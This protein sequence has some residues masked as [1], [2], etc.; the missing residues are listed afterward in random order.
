MIHKTAD[1][2][3]KKIGENTVIWQN[4]IVLENAEIGENCNINCHCF[5]ENDVKIGDNCTIKSGVYLWD[6]ISIE[7][8]V[9]IGP[10]VTFTNDKYPKSKIYPTK[11]DEILIKSN[12]SIGAGA[13]LLGGI[14]V[15]NS[16]I[17]GAGSVVTKNVPDYSIVKGNPAKISGWLNKDGT[18]MIKLNDNL[19][20]D[21]FNQKW[22]QNDGKIKL[23]KND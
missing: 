15:G 12:S 20:I 1:V 4:T 21:N 19:F 14:I 9:F 2:K 5:I 7:E 10:N 3:S 6:G 18:K 8:N 11:F 22:V 13:I 16:C 17:V 23:Y